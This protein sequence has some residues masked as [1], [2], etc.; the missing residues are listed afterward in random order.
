MTRYERIRGIILERILHGDLR[1]GELL[2]S[3]NELA[4][5]FGVTR[6]T[7]RKALSTLEDER[8][9]TTRQG[10]GRI[11]NKR[12]NHIVFDMAKLESTEF[13]ISS[14]GHK[15][16]EE[17][18]E[19]TEIKL[20]EKEATLLGC[21]EESHGKRLV[22]VRTVGDTPVS[23]SVNLFR[24]EY[25]PPCRFTGSLLHALEN[26]GVSVDYAETEMMVPHLSD[27][28]AKLLTQADKFVPII[29]LQQLHFDWKHN[30]I[31]LS[32]D[33]LNTDVF[34]LTMTRKR[35]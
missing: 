15:A 29:L 1:Q 14:A 2:P 34:T 28:Y 13:M 3:E 30:P 23:V 19:F 35:A 21:L 24:R 16:K 33:Y 22:R 12:L 26:N 25:T 6:V 27:V 5:E 11:V 31:F 7:V 9:L 4:K 18:R 32:Y 8:Y 10:I 20:N 17:I